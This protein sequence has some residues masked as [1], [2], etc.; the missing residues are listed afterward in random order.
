MKLSTTGLELIKKF[1]GLRLR[2]YVDVVG[3]L[4]VGYGHT[5]PDVVSGMVI[6]EEEAEAFL[7]KDV[8]SFENAVS[9]NTRVKLNQNEYEVL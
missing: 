7:L 1:E 9:S 8:R 3:V 2:S 6:S 5:G 4:T